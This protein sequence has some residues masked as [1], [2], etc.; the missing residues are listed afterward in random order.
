MIAE[1]QYR[2]SPADLELVLALVRG[3]SLAEA[4]KRL[5]VDA[6]TVFRAVQRLEKQLGQRLFER[7]RS[8]YL[9]GEQALALA[10]H[11]ERMEVALD[12]ARAEVAQGGNEVAGLVRLTTTDTMME[13]L[14]PALAGI[15]SR[16]PALEFELSATNQLANLSR[17][18]AD[19][20][21]RPS[22]N[23]PD[24][25]VGKQLGL[26]RYAVYAAP[27]YLQAHP[28]STALDQHV[29]VAPDDSLPTH[30]S[31]KWRQKHLPR[32]R[33]RYRCNSILS[34]AQTVRAGLG[35]GIFPCYMVKDFDGL[36]ALTEP[37]AD[38]EV[39]LWLLTHPESRHLRRVSVMFQ[40]LGQALAL[41]Q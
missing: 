30:P 8:G 14:L 35:V 18:E 11:G 29:W 3:G 5:E 39:G 15:A 16:H 41:P 12:Q 40:E 20:A 26:V 33:P 27:A 6:S 17:R 19:L 38:C 34:V 21:L 2:I 10:R 25:L 22:R 7:S 28:A 24:Y 13:L 37:L 23:P 36:V 1:T 31:V 32:L 4:A 9:P